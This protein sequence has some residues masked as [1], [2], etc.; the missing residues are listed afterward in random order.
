LEVFHATSPALSTFDPAQPWNSVIKDSIGQMASEFWDEELKD[1]CR[2]YTMKL[3]VGRGHRDMPEGGGD[4]D[5]EVWKPL[6]KPNGKGDGKGKKGKGKSKKSSGMTGGKFHTTANGKPLCFDW[7]NGLCKE[8]F[9]T[10]N[11][12][13]ACQLCRGNHRAKNCPK[14]KS[15][16]SEPADDDSKK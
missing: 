8:K 2:R 9:C 14:K 15:G 16:G 11:R 6:L 10:N 7:N 12:V 3:M 13:H 5:K 1:P 4:P